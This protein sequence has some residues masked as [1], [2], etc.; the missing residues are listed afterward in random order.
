MK[1][2]YFR[3]EDIPTVVDIINKEFEISIQQNSNSK[4]QAF[5]E[6]FNLT[7]MRAGMMEKWS[8]FQLESK[9]II[10]QNNNWCYQKK[11]VIDIAKSSVPFFQLLDKLG[12]Y[13]SQSEEEILKINSGLF[14]NVQLKD[15]K[16]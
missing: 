9:S 3:V 8:L 14:T 13:C 12:T 1:L 5:I 4:L 7:W 10:V 11:I 16:K 15:L 6:Y 2:A